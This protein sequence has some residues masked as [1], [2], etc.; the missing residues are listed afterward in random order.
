METVKAGV[1]MESRGD[2]LVGKHESTSVV[3]YLKEVGIPGACLP[4]AI[5]IMSF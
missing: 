4:F 5:G 2:F 3:Q 1:L